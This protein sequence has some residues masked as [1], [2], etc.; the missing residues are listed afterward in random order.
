MAGRAEQCRELYDCAGSV[1]ARTPDSHRLRR[2]GF[3]SGDTEV[4]PCHRIID[5]QGNSTGV[6][7]LT[8]YNLPRLEIAG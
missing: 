4:A 1:T 2:L 5:V 7:S 6:L 3:A 8:C